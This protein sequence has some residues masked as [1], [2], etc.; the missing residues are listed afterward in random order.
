MGILHTSLYH[1]CLTGLRLGKKLNSSLLLKA[2]F[3]ETQTPS[4]K[5]SKVWSVIKYGQRA[6]YV[7]PIVLVSSLLLSHHSNILMRAAKLVLIPVTQGNK[8]EL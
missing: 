4:G 3:L 6:F 5:A 7:V 8:L 2:I 1:R